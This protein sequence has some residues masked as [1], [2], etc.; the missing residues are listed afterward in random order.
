MPKRF[1]RATVAIVTTGV[2]VAGGVI[3]ASAHELSGSLSFEDQFASA[4][5]VEQPE[6]TESPD[7]DATSA[8]ILVIPTPEPSETPEA[9]ETPDATETPEATTED[10]HEAPEATTHEQEQ[11]GAPAMS[12]P[13]RDAEESRTGTS[14]EHD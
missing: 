13:T 9:A 3:A 11:E 14:T 2:L 6:P 7:V 1:P 8:P 4:P 5:R 12:A 10:A